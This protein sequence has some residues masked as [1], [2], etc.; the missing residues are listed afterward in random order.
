MQNSNNRV[1]HAFTAIADTSTAGTSM[2][3]QLVKVEMS[4]LLDMPATHTTLR[5][6][7]GFGASNQKL[8]DIFWQ[9]TASGSGN[10]PVQMLLHLY[11]AVATAKTDSQMNVS[12]GFPT[13]TYKLLN[14]ASST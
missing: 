7:G 14:A 10:N 2:L 4:S 1:A 5:G 12:Y 13:N 11:T 3:N 9:M 6:R 8:V